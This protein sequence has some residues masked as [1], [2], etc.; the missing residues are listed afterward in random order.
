MND[1]KLPPGYVPL[2]IHEL[3]SQPVK[4]GYRGSRPSDG[5]D[6]SRRN[7]NGGDRSKGRMKR[8]PRPDDRQPTED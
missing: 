6:R 1:S 7:N 2:T 8:R 3:N 4:Q 5:G